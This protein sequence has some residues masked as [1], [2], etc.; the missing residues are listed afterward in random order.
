MTTA[1]KNNYLHRHPI[2]LESNSNRKL[3]AELFIKELNKTDK[4]LEKS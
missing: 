4:K 3:E 2:L 1:T